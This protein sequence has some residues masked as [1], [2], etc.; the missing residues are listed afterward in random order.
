MTFRTLVLFVLLCG[1][2]GLVYADSYSGADSTEARIIRAPVWV[3]LEPQPGVM[4]SSEQGL[5]LP[6]RQALTEL[7]RTVLEGM[8]FGWR[9]TYTPFDKQRL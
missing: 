3:F 7:S 2:A 1:A 4:D 8:T 6:L 9:F 5:Q